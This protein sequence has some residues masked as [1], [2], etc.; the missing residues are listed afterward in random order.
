VGAIKP[1]KRTEFSESPSQGQLSR[2]VKAKKGKCPSL[3]TIAMRIL[4]ADEAGVRQRIRP[5][6][7][8]GGNKRKNED[9]GHRKTKPGRRRNKEEDDRFLCV[10]GKKGKLH[11]SESVDP[12][13]RVCT[14]RN[15]CPEQR[16][17][18]CLGT[19][20]SAML[21]KKPAKRILL[22]SRWD[23]IRRSGGE[24]W[25]VFSRGGERGRYDP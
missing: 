16:K 13:G 4:S 12:P 3:K 15:S 17:A 7:P 14:E 22:S 19:A 18:K 10:V 8:T 1:K 2:F 23:Q 9:Y 20:R 24:T 6:R 25:E 5:R 11:T 21:R